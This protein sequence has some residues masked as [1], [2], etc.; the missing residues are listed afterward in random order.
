LED[1]PALSRAAEIGL[2]IPVFIFDTNILDVL[3]DRDDRCV[4]FIH[5]SL[6]ELDTKLRQAE[7]ALV[8]RIGDPTELIPALATQLGASCIVAAQDFEPYAKQRDA[9]IANSLERSGIAFEHV[10]DHTIQ[11]PGTILSQAGTPISVFT[12]FKRAFLAKLQD[13]MVAECRFDKSKL[14]SATEL[15]EFQQPWTMSDIGFEPSELWIEP[16]EDAA[17]NRLSEFADSKM[18]EYKD[19]RDFPDLANTSV[20]S[21]HLRFGTIS[22]RACFRAA[23]SQSNAGAD[24]WLSELIWREFYMHVLHHWP[25]AVEGSFKREYDGIDWPGDEAHFEAWKE[26]RTGYPLVDAAMRC[27]NATGWMHNRLRMVVASFLVKDLLIDWRKGEAHFARYLLDFEL[28]SNNGG[29]QWSASTGC[30]AQ[31]Y[32]RI[33]NP[34]LQSMKFDSEGRFIRTWCPELSGFNG[35]KIH[36]PWETSMF[37]QMDAGCIL[38]EH[39]PWPIINHSV[40][41]ELAIHLLE[42]ARHSVAK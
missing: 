9:K 33:F 14:V 37:E 27:F 6:T 16:G 17:Q 24:C 29:W 25:H 19:K 32:F 23:L 35:E 8:V 5:R 4:T 31:P 41:K 40:Q 1:H 36:S 2:V 34:V 11:E 13:S 42:S 30:D 21:P 38:G 15:E 3:E 28:A 10:L 26:G 18:Q 12:P 7:S 22:T 39:Y 20:L